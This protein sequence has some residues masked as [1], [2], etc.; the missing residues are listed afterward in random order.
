MSYFCRFYSCR[1]HFM[2]LMYVSL[3]LLILLKRPGCLLRN[4][5]RRST[6]ELEIF[7]WICCLNHTLSSECVNFLHPGKESIFLIGFPVQEFSVI[8]AKPFMVQNLWI[9]RWYSRFLPSPS[10]FNYSCHPLS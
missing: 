7:T 10:H 2:G 4:N 8:T 5:S 6:T 3:Y 1:F 9:S